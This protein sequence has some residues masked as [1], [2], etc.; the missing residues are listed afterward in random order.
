MGSGSP[1]RG[2]VDRVVTG[3]GIMLWINVGRAG[4][5]RKAAFRMGTGM[6]IVR[7]VACSCA[8]PTSDQRQ[9]LDPLTAPEGRG[10]LRWD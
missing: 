6:N 3:A 7:G 2:L 8:S 9:S 10:F 1:R 4:V 5:P